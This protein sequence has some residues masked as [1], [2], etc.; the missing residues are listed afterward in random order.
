MQD[1]SMTREK[2][3]DQIAFQRAELESTLSKYRAI[4]SEINRLEIVLRSMGESLNNPRACMNPIV[5]SQKKCEECVFYRRCSFY[6]KE[7]YGRFKL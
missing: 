2:I 5:F 3:I 7:D 1:K 6:G 4:G